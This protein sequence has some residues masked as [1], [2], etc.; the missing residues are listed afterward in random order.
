VKPS[1]IASLALALPLAA[2]ASGS[3]STPPTTKAT[4]K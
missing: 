4:T 2:Y 3:S 1:L